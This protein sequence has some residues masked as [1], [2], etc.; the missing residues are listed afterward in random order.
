MTSGELADCGHE[1]QLSPTRKLEIVFRQSGGTLKLSDGRSYVAS[2]SEYVA[3]HKTTAGGNFW[4]RRVYVQTLV[5]DLLCL[6]IFP[7][8]LEGIGENS[9]SKSL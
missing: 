1:T 5:G 6:D 8:S 9:P 2:F 7:G 3:Q 4:C